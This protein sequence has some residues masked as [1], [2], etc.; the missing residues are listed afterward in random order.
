M[1]ILNRFDAGSEVDIV[2]YPARQLINAIQIILTAV[3]ETVEVLEVDFLQHFT[4]KFNT[5]HPISLPRLKEL[6]T[7]Y[8][9]ALDGAAIFK[10]CHQLRRLNVV[11]PHT[12]NLFGGICDIAP[13]LTHLHFSGIQRESDLVD[14]LEVALGITEASHAQTRRSSAAQLPSSVQKIIAKPAGPPAPTGWCG[15]HAASYE[16]LMTELR[17][18]NEEDDDRFVLLDAKD[19]TRSPQR[20]D[21]EWLDRVAGGEGCWSISDVVPKTGFR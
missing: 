1:R 6:T 2:N 12:S 10:P 9:F 14:K 4:T 8:G 19:N 21:D 13:F 17:R 11:Q 20:I 15:T 16:Y 18:L 7:H 5:T 3:A